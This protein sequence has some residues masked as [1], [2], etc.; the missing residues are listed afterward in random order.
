MAVGLVIA[1]VYRW[2]AIMRPRALKSHPRES[3]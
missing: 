3:V 1:A 2:R